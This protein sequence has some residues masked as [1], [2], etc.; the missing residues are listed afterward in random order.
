MRIFLFIRVDWR[1]FAVSIPNLPRG[2]VILAIANF[3]LSLKEKHL[4]SV[5]AVRGKVGYRAYG[6][7]V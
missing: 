5:Q 2:I 3:G 4:L 6:L 1:R 7:Q